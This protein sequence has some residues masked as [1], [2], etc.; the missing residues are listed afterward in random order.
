MFPCGLRVLTN[1]ARTLL[2]RD[3]K[4]TVQDSCVLLVG[5]EK[6]GYVSGIS[7]SLSK[8]MYLIFFLRHPPEVSVQIGKQKFYLNKLKYF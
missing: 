1:G 4:R 3:L 2:T 6:S 8:L 5:F 7:V